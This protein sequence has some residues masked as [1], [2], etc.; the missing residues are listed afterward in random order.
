MPACPR[1]E[2]ARVARHTSSLRG[3]GLR[4]IVLTGGPA[5]KR[6]VWG[7][8]RAGP[9]YDPAT[10]SVAGQLGQTGRLGLASGGSAEEERGA[11]GEPRALPSRP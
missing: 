2:A 10:G 3:E 6:A 11:P 7:G 9:T 8:A 4:N 1:G 5:R